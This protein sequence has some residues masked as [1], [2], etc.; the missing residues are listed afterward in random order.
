MNQR[1][2]VDL[3][4]IGADAAG[5][6]A[7]AC[8]AKSGA[9]VA[10][11][12]TGGEAPAEGATDE[13]PNFVWRILDLHLH[14]L[15]LDPAA[16][17]TT[18]TEK[19]ALSTTADPM[20]TGEALAARDP[21]LDHLWPAFAAEMKRV[22]ASEARGVDRFLSANALLDDYFADE[23]L[24]THLVSAFVAPFGL[25]G[26]EAGSAAALAGAG[27]AARR[28]VSA[29]ALHDALG[30]AAA[31]AGVESL[32][33]RLQTLARADGKSWKAIMDN[34]REAR[35][36]KAMASSALIGEAAGVRIA[37]DGSPLVRRT[38][39]EAVIR[40]RYDKRPNAAAL[41]EAGIFLTATD[42]AAIV[43]ARGAMIDGRIDE[44]PVLS[45]EAN[46]KEIIARA[47]FC[48]ARLRENG[49]ERDWTGQD[50]QILGRQAAS[51]IEKYF[52]G[53]LG[54]VR[55]IEVMVGAD[56]AAG[57]K[58]RSFDIPALPAPPPSHDPVGA[59][60]ALA[61]EIVRDE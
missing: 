3:L 24:K 23:E 37:C 48:P 43:R 12:P 13:P 4:I 61:L 18:L 29:H 54:A 52:G 30:A 35:A 45:F 25:A 16:P 22:I 32:S 7:A 46:G 19:G 44:E 8:A 56:P 15:R 49:E 42:R 17:R 6:A 11:A 50:R 51:L 10:L 57:L 31:K 38:G 60:A 1:A 27:D 41:K 47:P 14:D 20:R 34:G 55:E 33:G 59:A 58:R 5:L 40:I 39:A 36:R 9:S 53:G 26:D 2:A 28:R 21:T